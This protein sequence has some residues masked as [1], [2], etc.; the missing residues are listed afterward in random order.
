MNNKEWLIKK[1]GLIHLIIRKKDG[2]YAIPR[3]LK[4]VKDFHSDEENDLLTH[5]LKY[6]NEAALML[7][8]DEIK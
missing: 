5:A 2:I 6:N 4:T 3:N 8:F 1:D 7:D